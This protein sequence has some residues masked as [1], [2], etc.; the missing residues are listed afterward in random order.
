MQLMG[1]KVTR[2]LHHGAWRIIEHE[3]HRAARSDTVRRAFSYD[4][5]IVGYIFVYVIFFIVVIA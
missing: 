4:G 5:R 3:F 1:K 2:D